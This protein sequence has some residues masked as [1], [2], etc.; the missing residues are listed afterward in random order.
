MG[1]KIALISLGLIFLLFAFFQWNDVDS[2]KWIIYYILVAAMC[3][4][5][6]FEVNKKL[7]IL[8]L[9]VFSVVWL[10]TLF[11][12]AWSWVQD[13]MP[14]IVSSMKASSPYIELVREFLGLL[15]SMLVLL[16]LF[17]LEKKPKVEN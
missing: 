6:F 17:F 15:I 13:G 16:L 14:S 3:F 7:Y 4:F 11:P 1:K 12:S 8:A 10:L 2:M 5:S 9:L